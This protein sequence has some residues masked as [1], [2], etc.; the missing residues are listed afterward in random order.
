[1]EEE[2]PYVLPTWEVESSHSHD[3][4]NDVFPLDEAILEAMSRVEKP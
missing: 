1:M 4:L 3:F 2:D